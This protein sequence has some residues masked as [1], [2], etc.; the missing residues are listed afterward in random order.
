MLI[1]WVLVYILVL[2]PQQ[3]RSWPMHAL[4]VFAC[5]AFMSVFFLRPLW[6]VSLLDLSER[7]QYWRVGFKYW[8]ALAF[9]VLAPFSM[10]LAAIVASVVFVACFVY[11]Y[12]VPERGAR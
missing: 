10:R 9:A 1:T 12:F 5:A 2:A 8:V 11:I 4:I 3:I 7:K 6:G